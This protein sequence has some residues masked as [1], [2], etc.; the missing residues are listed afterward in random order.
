MTI[1]IYFKSHDRISSSLQARSEILLRF[2]GIRGFTSNVSQ[3]WGRMT[4]GCWDSWVLF[5]SSFT[6]ITTSRSLRWYSLSGVDGVVVMANRNKNH[7]SNQN[8]SLHTHTPTTFL[9]VSFS[10]S[11]GAHGSAFCLSRVGRSW[12]GHGSRGWGQSFWLSM[13]I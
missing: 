4:C 13:Q 7:G 8:F 9:E 11:A 2:A 5:V 3:S 1:K 6:N 12:K 10:S